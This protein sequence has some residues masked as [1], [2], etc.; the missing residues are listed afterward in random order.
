MGQGGLIGGMKSLARRLFTLL[1]FLVPS[2]V[3]G[4]DTPKH[5]NVLFIL[6]DDLRWDHLSCAGH[7]N[8]KTPNIDRLANEGVHFRNM[9]CT[10]SLCS[11]SRASIISGLYA[12]THGVVNN[13]TEFPN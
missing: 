1:I 2:A 4:A 7:P 8:L 5:P 6:C 3:R 10:T 12:H 9:F 11:P 13:F